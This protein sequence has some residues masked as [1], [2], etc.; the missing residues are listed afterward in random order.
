M[1]PVAGATL[2]NQILGY[3]SNMVKIPLTFP[4]VTLYHCD[5]LKLERNYTP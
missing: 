5:I 1:S 2:E 4:E 3:H